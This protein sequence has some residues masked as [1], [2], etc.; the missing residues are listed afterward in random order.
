MKNLLLFCSLLT[1]GTVAAQ[2]QTERGR[3]MAGGSG[4]FD[5]ATEKSK[6]GT[7]QTD[8]KY[9][10]YAADM[11]AGIF[12]MDGFAI[13][14]AAD[15][16]SLQRTEAVGDVSTTTSGTVV[17]PFARF[18]TKSHVFGETQ[19]GFGSGKTVRE[20]NPIDDVSRQRFFSWSAGV[21]YAFF[22]KGN[23]AIEPLLKYYSV[24][25][26]NKQFEA[27]QVKRSGINLNIGLQ[28]FF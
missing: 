26:T 5:F 18:Y 7:G 24:S 12:M 27:M 3:I 19:L 17:G 16:Y 11:K 8:A 28:V 1:S 10:N 20:N 23:I 2:S 13:G 15:L 14:A 6:S 9:R 4:G 21:G 22:M 25:A